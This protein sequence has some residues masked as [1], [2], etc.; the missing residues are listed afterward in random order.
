MVTIFGDNITTLASEFAW[1]LFYGATPAGL[2][3]RPA[4]YEL[5]SPGNAIDSKFG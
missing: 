4:D 3:R 5:S 1:K 2:N